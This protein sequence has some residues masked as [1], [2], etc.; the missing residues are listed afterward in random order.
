MM[1]AGYNVCA[2][3]DL[4]DRSEESRGGKVGEGDSSRVKTGVLEYDVPATNE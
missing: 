4:Q 3:R 2:H 1:R